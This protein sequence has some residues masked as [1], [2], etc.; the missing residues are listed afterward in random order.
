LI[1]IG[2]LCNSATLC[3]ITAIKASIGGNLLTLSSSFLTDCA[4]RSNLI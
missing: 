3:D 2:A 4:A 1:L